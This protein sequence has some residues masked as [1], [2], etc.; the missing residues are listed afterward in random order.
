MKKI[1]L[2]ALIIFALFAIVSCKDD[3]TDTGKETKKTFDENKE[4]VF[5]NIYFFRAYGQLEGS[6]LEDNRDLKP[7]VKINP[8]S[9]T[10]TYIC[11]DP[12]CEHD[13]YDCPFIYCR[14]GYVSGNYFF[15]ARGSI[16]FDRYTL[17]KSGSL[18][19]CVY[20]IKNSS[21]KKIAEYEDNITFIGGTED[22][23]YYRISQYDDPNAST[24]VAPLSELRYVFYRADAKTGNVI[25]LPAYNDY[26]NAS[27]Q[28]SNWDYPNLYDIINKKIYW[29][30]YENEKIIC[31]TTDLDGENKEP[32]DLGEKFKYMFENIASCYDSGYFY[33]NNAT[34]LSNEHDDQ[35]TIFESYY[36][37]YANNKLYRLA[38]SGVELEIIAERVVSFVPCGNK[39]YYTVL[40][41]E[42]EFLGY[43]ETGMWWNWNWSGGKIY[44]MNSDGSDKKLLCETG[45]NLATFKLYGAFFDAKTVKDVDYIVWAFLNGN[46]NFVSS[47]TIIINASTGEFTVVSVPE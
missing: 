37:T 43:D 3:Y 41:D 15:Y 17:E 44:V 28:S 20:D 18:S 45:Y 42:P 9:K 4:I 1:I 35:L 34:E 26:R 32:F 21:S 30:V 11:T 25:E 16:G 33:S 22:Y 39:I 19:L 14:S 47:D 8:I 31:Y 29:T 46:R 13:S 38:L 2:C 40:E 12:L 5:E 36:S 24:M 27:G 23:V 7:P 6:S 10:V